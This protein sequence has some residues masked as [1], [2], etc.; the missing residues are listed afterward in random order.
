MT[1][2]LTMIGGFRV[3]FAVVV[4]KNQMLAF[5][6]HNVG[7]TLEIFRMF[8]KNKRARIISQDHSRR[9]NETALVVNAARVLRRTDG[10]VGRVIFVAVLR[11]VGFS[12]KDCVIGIVQ[13]PLIF[14]FLSYCEKVAQAIINCVQ[15]FRIRLFD[16]INTRAFRRLSEN[17]KTIV[18]D[19]SR[20]IYQCAVSAILRRSVLQK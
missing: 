4:I 9:V 3:E 7:N 16:G 12:D 20:F 6:P 17:R 19:S 10:D 13:T 14:V 2:A 11:S 8:S 5:K 15:H 1:A 18:G